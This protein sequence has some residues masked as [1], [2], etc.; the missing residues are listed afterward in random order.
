MPPTANAPY[1]Y[2]P[3]S[4]TAKLASDVGT[5]AAMVGQ[6]VS[7]EESPGK[8]DTDDQMFIGLDQQVRFPMAK[9]AKELTLTLKAISS[10]FEAMC[11]TSY[12]DTSKKLIIVLISEGTNYLAV[13]SDVVTKT[14]TYTGYVSSELV[15]SSRKAG[16]TEE[17]TTTLQLTAAPTVAIA[18]GV[19]P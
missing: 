8:R 10:E 15:A 13:A 19:T 17:Y 11:K 7:A 9:S 3:K 4:I 18:G 2:V 16:E 14:T 1:R 12:D 5:A 6:V